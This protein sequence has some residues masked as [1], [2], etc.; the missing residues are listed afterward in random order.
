MAEPE[1]TGFRVRVP[2]ILVEAKV[3]V[4]VTVSSLV[5]V[6]EADRL[7]TTAFVAVKLVKNADKAVSM[8]AKKLVAVALVILAFWRVR[9]VPVAFSNTKL[10]IVA[11]AIGEFGKVTDAL[12]RSTTPLKVVV[13]FTTTGPSR[14]VVP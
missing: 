3:E 14:V 5:R 4:P 9:L 7:V 2:L 11:F 1:A 8:S 6:E 10:V 13:P 12:E